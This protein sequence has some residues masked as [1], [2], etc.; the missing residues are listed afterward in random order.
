KSLKII[1]KIGDLNSVLMPKILQNRLKICNSLTTKIVF[2]K[3]VVGKNAPQ[4]LNP[5][6]FSAHGKFPKKLKGFR[7]RSSMSKSCQKL[8]KSCQNVVEKLS[9][10]LSNVVKKL[11]KSNKLLENFF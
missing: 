1:H 2:K 5:H 11:S 3:P 6:G 4:N 9:K 7:V 10:K 8:L